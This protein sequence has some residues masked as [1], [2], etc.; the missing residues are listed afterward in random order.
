MFCNGYITDEKSAALSPVHVSALQHVAQRC[1]Q[2][3]RSLISWNASRDP[4]T[5]RLFAWISGHV[6][7]V[8]IDRCADACESTRYLHRFFNTLLG[9]QD[10]PGEPEHVLNQCQEAYDAFYENTLAPTARQVFGKTVH[11]QP[12]RKL[13]L[14]GNT[15][16]PQLLHLDSLW[17][18]MVGNVYLRP[19]GSEDVPLRATIFPEEP[20]P[21][22]HPRDLRSG[23]GIDFD[24]V[25]GKHST[26]WNERKDVGPGSVG[27]NR[28]V[29]FCGN[30]VHG[31]PGPD[32][33][34]EA[35]PR[36]VMFQQARADS[37]PAEDI[38]DVQHFEFTLKHTAYGEGAETKAALR[39]TNGRWRSHF[40]DNCGEYKKLDRLDMKNRRKQN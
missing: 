18:T 36:I 9:G 26:P 29:L 15:C 8:D 16:Q 30:V 31:G 19:K 35:E 7:Q 4:M 39:A 1:W 13:L 27:H 6:L 22:T 40:P 28:A 2:E 14:S 20:I 5:P 10:A 12:G 11:R 37:S 25:L 38:S 23:D 34:K 32:D 21:Q 17:P 33:R 24:Q 3:R